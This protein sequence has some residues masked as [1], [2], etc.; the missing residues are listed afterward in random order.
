MPTEVKGSFATTYATLLFIRRIE[1]RPKCRMLF[2]APKYPQRF[3][4]DRNIVA[5]YRTVRFSRLPQLSNNRF[6]Q[7]RTMCFRIHI[8]TRRCVRLLFDHLERPG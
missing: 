3:D 1:L 8:F 6:N 7:P 4:E 5:P 2:L